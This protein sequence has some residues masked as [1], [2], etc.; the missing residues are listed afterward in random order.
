MSLFWI[1][2]IIIYIIGGVFAWN[3]IKEWDN[4]TF[5]KICFTVFWPLGLIL[6]AIHYIHNL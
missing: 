6:Y 1:I 4:P 5:E 2:A 3:K